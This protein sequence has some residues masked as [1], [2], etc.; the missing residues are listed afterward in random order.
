MTKSP[1]GPMD[2][3]VKGVQ[4]RAV[5]KAEVQGISAQGGT[6]LYDTA[7]ASYKFV[8]G[9]Q[10]PEAINAVV[11]LTDGMNQDNGGISLNQLLTGLSTEQGDHPV[12]MFTISYGSDADLE[13]LRRIA[14][15]TNGASYDS[16]DPTSINRVF[17][18][19][20]SNF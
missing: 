20:I 15:A 11:L 12:R 4:R 13:V 17:T 5:I 14:Q 3:Q 6:G 1:I 8:K 9:R 19:A 2:A 16:S 18:M 7:L 10:S